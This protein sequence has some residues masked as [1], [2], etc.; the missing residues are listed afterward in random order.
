MSI[1]NIVNVSISRDTSSVSRAGFGTPL[2]L[3]TNKGFTALSSVYGS[4]NDVLLDF[5]ASDPEALAASAVFSQ[6]ITVKQLMI[7]RRA[8]SDLTV[9]TIDTVLPNTTYTCTVNGVVFSF[10]SDISPL[11]TEIALGLASAIQAGSEPVTA[12]DNVDGSFDLTADVASVVYSVTVDSKSS[13]AFVETDT[14]ANDIS[15][16]SLENDSWYGLVLTSRVEADQLA[17]A[18]YIETQSK[19]FFAG[20]ADA[21]IA[22]TTNA[23]DSTTIAAVFK[24]LGY[25]RSAVFYHPAA[26]TEYIEAAMFGVILPL[27]PGAYTAALKDLSGIAKDSI[28]PTQRTNI[29]AKNANMYSEVGGVGI[30]E[31][32]TVGEG[33][34]I[35]VIILV[36][37]IDA[38]MTEGVFS[39]LARLPKVPYTDAGIAAVEGEMKK[40]LQLGQSFGGIALDPSFVINVPLASEISQADKAARTLNGVSFS[41]TLTGAIHAVNITGTVTL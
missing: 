19:I 22:D 26:A 16:I 13:M 11:D 33:E 2:I 39:L 35:D 12:S 24:S 10:V 37:W 6:T 14:V 4:Y 7:G 1:D 32:G 3:G 40:V 18:A 31:F 25:A 9:I 27:D 28:T 30:V 41:A 20:S 15:N 29:L 17:A 21:D 23:A 34:Y 38:R 5:N 8:T 36:D